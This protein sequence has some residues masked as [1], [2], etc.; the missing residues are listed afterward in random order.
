MH[1]DNRQGYEFLCRSMFNAHIKACLDES[2]LVIAPAK[3]LNELALDGI[4]TNQLINLYEMMSKMMIAHNGIGLA[5]PQVGLPYRF[6]VV[7]YGDDIIGMLNPVVTTA[8]DDAE[9]AKEGCLSVP[10][11]RF[12]VTRPQKLSVEYIDINGEEQCKRFVGTTARCIQHEI[13]HLDGITIIQSG[14]LTRN[15]RRVVLSDLRKYKRKL[16]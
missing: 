4:Y 9:S 8:T 16:K 12:S 13:D 7:Q 6:I 11:Y 15:R 1:M 10:G 3:I 2:K 14:G 5:G